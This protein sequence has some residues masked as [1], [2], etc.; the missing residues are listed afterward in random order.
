[1]IA[2]EEAHGTDSV[3]SLAVR[4]DG[5]G[6]IKNTTYSVHSFMLC[7]CLGFMSGGADKFVRFWD[8]TVIV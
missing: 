3:W 8:F 7:C 2:D 5:K 1:M 6:F 4:P